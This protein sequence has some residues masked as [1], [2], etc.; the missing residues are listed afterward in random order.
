MFIFPR[1]LI[2]F[3]SQGEHVHKL[4]IFGSHLNF[5][6]EGEEM[7]YSK[8]E[9]KNSGL[10]SQLKTALNNTAWQRGLSW[11]NEKLN[12]VAEARR[13]G[14]SEEEIFKQLKIAGLIDA[15]AKAIM[16]DA[17][18]LE[19]EENPTTSQHACL[20]C[21][22]TVPINLDFCSETCAKSYSHKNK[23]VNNG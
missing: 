8:K 13:R 1:F 12:A 10:D 23:R 3:S 18:Y 6:Q 14:I 9:Q 17:S 4:D 7:S 20:K 19:N 2:I 21:G 22:K 15:T 5:P 11:R 16:R